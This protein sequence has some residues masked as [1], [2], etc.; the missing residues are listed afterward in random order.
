M[1]LVFIGSRGQLSIAHCDATS[2]SVSDTSFT[3]TGRSLGVADSSRY[4]LVGVASA[5][6]PSAVTVAGSSAS[7]LVN[8]SNHA[9]IW[10]VALPSGTSG[11]VVVTVTS[12]GC[13]I[14]IASVTGYPAG[15]LTASSTITAAGS[16]T[17]PADGVGFGIGYS[18]TIGP[19]D[20]LPATWSG[21]TRISSSEAS[22]TIPATTSVIVTSSGLLAPSSDSAITANVT[23]WVSANKALAAIAFAPPSG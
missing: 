4:I 5:A 23:N 16:I 3:F 2:S 7:L 11:T 10:G 20:T 17:I 6:L 21:L 12:G 13:A 1:P 8:G 9:T 15:A 18:V 22:W 14:E 19:S